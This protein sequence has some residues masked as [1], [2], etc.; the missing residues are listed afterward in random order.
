MFPEFP[1][2][3]TTALVMVVTAFV[4]TQVAIF[5]TTVYLHRA[6]THKGV[7]F[8]SPVNDFFKTVTWVTTGI[9]PRQWVAV[10][11][12]HHAHTDTDQDP[13]SPLILGWWTVQSKNVFLYRDAAGDPDVVDKYAKDLPETRWDRALFNHAWV[14]LGLLG[15]ALVLVLGIVPGLLTVGIHVVMY[16]ALSGSVNGPGHHFGRKTFPDNSGTNLRWLTLLTAG[17]GLHN[18]HHAA[19]TSARF[20]RKWSDLDLGWW[21]I[22]GARGLKLADVRHSDVDA[23]ARKAAPARTT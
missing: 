19:P 15:A 2:M 12:K 16:L 14:G 20:A 3:L 13:H 21:V 1:P 5:T 7:T 17:E 4:I 9:R 22:R 18:H 6:L 10:H 11:R 8:R 23:L